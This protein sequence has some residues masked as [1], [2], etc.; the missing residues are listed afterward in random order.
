[1][2]RKQE[3]SKFSKNSNADNDNNDTDLPFHQILL[4][5][6]GAGALSSWITSPLDM[7][8][9]RIQ[10][11][12]GSVSNTNKMHRQPLTNNRGMIYV[13]RNIFFHEGL[14]GLFRGAGARVL[15]FTPSAAI[16]MTFYEKIR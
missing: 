5:S 3:N 14:S 16:T 13:L 11:E 7:A 4:C 6:S 12:Q 8:K 1:M 9:L 2:I 15:H 10:I